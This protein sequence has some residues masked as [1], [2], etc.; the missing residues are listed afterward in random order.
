MLNLLGV[1]LMV[2][3]IFN[4]DNFAIILC[5]IISSWN[6]VKNFAET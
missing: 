1:E 6:K 2:V 3:L 5:K 4:I